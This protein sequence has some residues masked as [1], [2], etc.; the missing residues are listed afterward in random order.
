MSVYA[1]SDRCENNPGSFFTFLP[2]YGKSYLLI[3]NFAIAYAIRVKKPKNQT[4]N[5]YK[6]ED[7]FE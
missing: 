3:I 2:I 5:K 7:T 1:S 4:L 6:N